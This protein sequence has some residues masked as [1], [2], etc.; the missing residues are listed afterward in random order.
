MLCPLCK[1]EL[2]KVIFYK[3]EVDYCS[4]C[5]GLWFEKDE[6]RQTKDEK[7]KELSW[8]DIDLWK[9]KKKFKISEGIKMCPSC[10]VPLYQINYGDSRISVDVCNL[11]QGIW[12]DRGE[13]KKIINYLKDK[14]NY[15]ILNNYFKNLAKQTLEV[16]IGPEGFRSELNDFLVLFKVLEYKLLIKYPEIKKIISAL[17]R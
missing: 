4:N 5:L 13:F 11:C 9:E 12:L 8:V 7:D 17:S 15:E 16:F 2:K 10:F 14:G 6:L 3:T 1:I